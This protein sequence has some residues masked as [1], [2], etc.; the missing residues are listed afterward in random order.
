MP[1]AL[2]VEDDPAQLEALQ[3]LVEAEGFEVLACASIESALAALA[4]T[5]FDVAAVD[6]RL[7][8]GSGLDLVPALRAETDV[9]LITGQAS[10]ESAVEAFRG[11]AVDYLTKPIDT[12]RLRSILERSRRAAR[13]RGQVSS[14]RGEL[15]EFGRF[16]RL[17]GRSPAMQEMYDQIQ[18]VAPTDATV[19]I[20]GE[21]GAGKEVV[22]ATI[23]EL[24]GRSGKAFCPINC[25]A[26]AASLIESELFGHER[27][28]FTGA[29][30]RHEGVF[31]RAHEGTLFLDEITEMPLDLQV[32]LLRALESREIQR[33]GGE[34]QIR[35][36]VR[37]IAATNRDPRAAVAE[38]KL[39]QDLFYRL[40]VFPIQIPPLR[41]R[42]DDILILADHFV[43]K[44]SR[45]AGERR[46]LTAA[47]K[48]RLLLH[49]W[50]GNVRELEN[51]VERACIMAEGDIGPEC[52]PFVSSAT[53]ATGGDAVDVRVGETLASAERKLTLATLDRY[54][55]KRRAAE[56]LGISLKTL[57]NRLKGYGA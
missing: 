31:E 47:A 25:G 16:G 36:D 52:F 22:A 37:V 23:H 42:G 7:R 13:L 41:E 49:D 17:I 29:L 57:Y 44:R 6:L 24:G 28:S 40:L 30:R 56:V 38:G 11:G 9:V 34:H 20:T 4:S 26:V 10:V 51:A 18:K 15:R 1:S 55:E 2:I 32:K 21:T 39:R 8:D 19:L 14:L 43:E 3:K 50:P 5:R 27:G 33:I 48:Q 35:V 46:R 45:E 53:P 12:T 54:A